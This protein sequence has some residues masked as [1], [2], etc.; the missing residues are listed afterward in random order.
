[1]LFFVMTAKSAWRNP[2]EMTVPPVCPNNVCLTPRGSIL[3]N[4]AILYL[5]SLGNESQTGYEMKS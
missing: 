4:S 3:N 5:V 2:S 1:M